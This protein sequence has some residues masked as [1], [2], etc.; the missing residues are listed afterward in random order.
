MILA[1]IDIEARS[2]GIPV[3]KAMIQPYDRTKLQPAS[4][5]C[6]LANKFRVFDSHRCSLINLADPSS[7]ADISRE[8]SC[9][10]GM[11][12]DGPFILHPGEFALG[13]TEEYFVIP[14]D[15][16][17]RIEGKSS[18]GRLGLLTHI[19]AGF[20]DPGF[21]GN[22]TLEFVNLQRMPIALHP[23]QSICQMSFS[24][25]TR[26]ARKRYV[27]HYQGDKGPVASRYDG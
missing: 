11:R 13:A 8:V 5:D 3:S 23:G 10:I 18:L 26:E 14:P 19:T 16:T 15:I 4:Y 25:L 9:C 22:V 1:D 6:T 17:G 21:H 27:G 7:Y 12:G 20:I 24:L 2:V